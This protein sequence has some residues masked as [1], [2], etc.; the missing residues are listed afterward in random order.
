MDGSTF[1]GVGVTLGMAVV[2][3]LLWV[4]RLQ[5]RVAVLEDR[6]K[7]SAKRTEGLENRAAAFDIARALSEQKLSGVIIDVNIVRADLANAV[8]SVNEIR[9]QQTETRGDMKN[10]IEA[11]HQLRDTVV[12]WERETRKML[13]AA[14]SNRLSQPA[15]DDTPPAGLP[16]TSREP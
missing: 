7:E 12:R 4:G 9:L 5:Q 3:A 1:V 15:E 6:D 11:M 10:V 2:G 8:A 14:F 13:G 16:R